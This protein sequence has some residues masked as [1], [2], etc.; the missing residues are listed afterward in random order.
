MA[1]DLMRVGLVLALSGVLVAAGVEDARIR[2][3]ADRKSMGIALL[4]PLWWW[5]NGASLWP[6]AAIQ[7]AVSL[8]V[9]TLFAFAFAKG[10]MGGGDVKLITAVSLWLPWQHLIGMLMTMSI[11]GGIATLAMMAERYYHRRT[12]DPQQCPA[13]E[14]PYG[15]AIAIA[16]LLAVREPILNQFG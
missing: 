10:A 3:I 1:A 9:F 16:A 8:V 5:A 7:V 14:V 4:A 11:V 12:R 13:I 2:E 6:G 15:I